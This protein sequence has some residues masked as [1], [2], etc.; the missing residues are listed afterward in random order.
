[1]KSNIIEFEKFKIKTSDNI[2]YPREDIDIYPKA[3]K[4]IIKKNNKILELGTGTGAISISLAKN[5]KNV[6]ITATDINL[7]AI[8]IAKK[9]AEIN[10]VEHII[11][12]KKSNWFSN[13]DNIKY[14]F[15][16]ANP[17]YLAKKNSIH[18]AEL[19]DPNNSLYANN[20]GL[21]DIY[22]IIKLG[23]NYLN[24]NSFIIIEHSHNQTLLLKE[25]AKKY[26]LNLVNTEK[27]NLGF[28]RVSVF[29]N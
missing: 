22:K 4:N 29:L 11:K 3:L 15:I 6:K 13:I 5:F 27:D 1:M 25:Y 8:K 21:A 28:N 7:S 20:D 16:I 12:F 2:F 9:N 17:P 14:D 26:N 10:N 18:Y 23:I 24:K 19:L